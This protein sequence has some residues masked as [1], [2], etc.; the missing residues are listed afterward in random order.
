MKSPGILIGGWFV[1]GAALTLAGC[2]SSSEPNTDEA[3][4]SP[5]PTVTSHLP[6][7]C[8]TGTD[9][10]D[11]L[12]DPRV[13]QVEV[14]GDCHSIA[15]ITALTTEQTDLALLVC[16][17]TAELAFAEEAVTEV[18]VFDEAGAELAGS[19]RDQPCAAA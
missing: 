6:A 14:V 9:L 3:V 13:T 12:S 4:P 2:S 15:V 8:A 5:S 19:T 11:R 10:A 1:A 17:S 16:Q 18:N 7:E